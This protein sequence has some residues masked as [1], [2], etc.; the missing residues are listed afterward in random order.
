MKNLKPIKWIQLVKKKQS[1][2]NV[3]KSSK[4]S[5]ITKENINEIMLS[6]IPGVSS[7]IANAIMVQYKVLII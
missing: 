7:I 6:Q 1:Y 2:T 3:I 4:K 5:N